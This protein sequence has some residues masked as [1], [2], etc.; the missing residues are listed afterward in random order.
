MT[1]RG[2]VILGNE[3]VGTF[4]VKTN[5]VAVVIHKVSTS[6]QELLEFASEN[7]LTVELLLKPEYEQA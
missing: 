5:E 1:I 2:L 7:G 4:D 3:D 6:F